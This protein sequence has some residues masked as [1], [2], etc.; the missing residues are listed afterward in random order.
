MNTRAEKRIKVL[1]VEDEA[2]PGPRLQTGWEES[3]CSILAVHTAGEGV[4]A[5]RRCQPDAIVLDLEIGGGSGLSVLEQVREWSRIPIFVVSPHNDEGEKVR[6]FDKGASDFL[7]QP[8]SMPELLARLRAA[9]RLGW[10]ESS[11]G[12]FRTGALSVDLTSRT[13]RVGRKMVR[14]TGTEYSL[15]QLLLTEPWIGYRLAVQE[16][17]AVY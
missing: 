14:L 17:R 10:A 5:A 7:T 12:V 15:L 16:Q 13:V 3:G 4:E 9:V 11:A 6:A 8:F 1:V 2:G